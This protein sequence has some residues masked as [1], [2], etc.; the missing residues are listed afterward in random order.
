[1]SINPIEL[2]VIWRQTLIAEHPRLS[3]LRELQALAPYLEE[4]FRK[5]FTNTFESEVVNEEWKL[6]QSDGDEHIPI[7]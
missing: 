3:N 4:V 1:M 7:E 2:V 6:L 5:Q